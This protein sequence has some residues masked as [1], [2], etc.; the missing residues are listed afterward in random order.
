MI[1][2]RTTRTS[3]VVAAFTS[4]FPQAV[5][6]IDGIVQPAVLTEWCT[7]ERLKKCV[8]FSLQLDGAELLWFHDDSRD[9]LASDETIVL[10]ERL[11]SQRVLRYRQG[12]SGPLPSAWRMLGFWISGIVLVALLTLLLV[13]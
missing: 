3:T 4:E 8:D 10:V 11:A 6:R 2:I 9:M 1:T 12:P 5:A 7:N 13:A